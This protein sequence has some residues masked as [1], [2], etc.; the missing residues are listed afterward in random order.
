[1]FLFY[2]LSAPIA[3]I[4]SNSQNKLVTIALPSAAAVC[5]SSIKMFLREPKRTPYDLCFQLFGVPVRIHYQFWIIQ[6][7]LA[8]VFVCLN[9][10]ESGPILTACMLLSIIIHELGHVLMGRVLGSRGSIVVAPL[11]GVA[12]GST[13]LDERWKRV[14]VIAA[15]PV[16]SLLLALSAWLVLD[17]MPLWVHRDLPAELTFVFPLLTGMNTIWAIV[18]LIPIPP[19]DGGQL[20]L[21]LIGSL[22]HRSKAP[23]EQDPDWW[24]RG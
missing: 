4:M 8:L 5:R 18:N 10:W 6:G 14:L 2:R 19:L 11:Y 1:M 12:V 3:A 15:G 16:A 7:F 24:K 9:R 17:W 23:W 13:A 22:G 20:M 21:E